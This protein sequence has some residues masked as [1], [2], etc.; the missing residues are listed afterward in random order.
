MSL[1]EMTALVYNYLP[2]KKIILI[3]NQF[4]NQEIE[5]FQQKIIRLSF[6]WEFNKVISKNYLNLILYNSQQINFFV[7]DEYFQGLLVIMN[8]LL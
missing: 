4:R 1:L 6:P 8:N 2:F 5:L 7:F 3:T